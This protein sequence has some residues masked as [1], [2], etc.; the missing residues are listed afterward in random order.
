MRKNKQIEYENN[1]LEAKSQASHLQT[2][3]DK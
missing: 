3:T 2:P 1:R